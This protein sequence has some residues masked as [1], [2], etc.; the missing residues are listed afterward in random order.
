MCSVKLHWQTKGSSRFCVLLLSVTF[1][2]VLSITGEIYSTTWTGE[3]FV[4][5]IEYTCWEG[6]GNSQSIDLILDP[7]N[8]SEITDVSVWFF[9]CFLFF[10]EVLV[11]YF[12]KIWTSVSKFQSVFTLLFS[13]RAFKW[14]QNMT[15]FLWI[16]NRINSWF[17]FS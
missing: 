12:K 17:Y 14:K 4:S 7:A 15:S 3:V 9:F 1:N 10:E 13:G 2:T 11:V 8:Q 5:F 16:V 6:M